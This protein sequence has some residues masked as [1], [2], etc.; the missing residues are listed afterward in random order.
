[1]HEALL[2]RRTPFG[3]GGLGIGD[4]E[5]PPLLEPL[6]EPCVDVF[7]ATPLRAPPSLTQTIGIGVIPFALRYAA[8]YEL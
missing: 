8:P 3:I 5:P 1:M 4:P 6:S 7:R 2:K